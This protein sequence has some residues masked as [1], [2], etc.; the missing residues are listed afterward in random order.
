[1]LI[2]LALA[3]LTPQETEQLTNGLIVQEM[4]VAFIDEDSQRYVRD[5][6]FKAGRTNPELN[7]WFNGV[8]AGTDE[9]LVKTRAFP[10]FNQC[11]AMLPRSFQ[12]M[13]LLKKL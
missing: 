9:E 12:Q 11:K 1:M 10:S 8:A 4:C 13:E 5:L 6:K 7:S 2:F 3:A